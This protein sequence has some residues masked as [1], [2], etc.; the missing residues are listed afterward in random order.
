ME[1]ATAFV[2]IRPQGDG[3]ESEVTSMVSGMPDVE[4]PVIADVART[5]SST[6]QCR[7]PP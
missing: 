3:F 7:T 1:I 4:I 2:A 6:R 5:S